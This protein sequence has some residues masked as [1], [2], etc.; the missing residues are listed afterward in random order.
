M[1]GIDETANNKA[2]P[3]CVIMLADGSQPVLDVRYPR[4]EITLLSKA[5]GS[6]ASAKFCYEQAEL[7]VNAIATKGA[8]SLPEC[9]SGMSLIGDITGPGETTDGRRW[10]R[11]AVQ[12]IN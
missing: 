2:S 3:V 11:I 4:V 1:G 10:Y 6:S 5:A 9:V 7:I 12:I 8:Q